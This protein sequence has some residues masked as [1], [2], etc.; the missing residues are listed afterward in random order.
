MRTRLIVLLLV[1]TTALVGGCGA[2]STPTPEPTPAPTPTPSP[3]CEALA[4]IQASVDALVA[5]SPLEAGV[6]G[7]REALRAITDSIRGLRTSTG[8]QLAARVDALEQAAGDLEAALDGLGSGGIAGSLIE[9]G[10]AVAAVG[11][12][13]VELRSEARATFAECG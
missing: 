7:Y 1:A 9:I 3:V 11:T 6:E 8:D 2:G 10:T 13:L 12:A 4:D 5:L